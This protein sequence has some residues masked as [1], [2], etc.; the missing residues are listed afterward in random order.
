[1]GKSNPEYLKTVPGLFVDMNMVSNVQKTKG[2]SEVETIG[3]ARRKNFLRILLIAIAL[4]IVFGLFFLPLFKVV[5]MSVTGPEG[6]TLAVFKKLLTS[7]K[8]MRVLKNTMYINIMSS[9]FAAVIGV[10]I[11]YF[12]AY[13][14]I[15]GKRALNLVALIPLVIPGYILT[16]AWMQLFATNGSFAMAL[17]NY[18]PNIKMPNIYSY[19]GIIFVFA[20]LLK[21]SPKF[22]NTLIKVSACLELISVIFL[23]LNLDKNFGLKHN[24]NIFF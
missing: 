17:R 13:T 20:N 4:V 7:K 21:A 16:L 1:M 14:D 23:K 6:F 19:T 3:N 11:S 9:F 18:F 2:G 8:M 15:R 22:E 12:M 5:V 24:L 10:I